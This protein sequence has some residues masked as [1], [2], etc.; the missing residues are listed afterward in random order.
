MTESKQILLIYDDEDIE[1]S[2]ERLWEDG[3]SKIG[4]VT[5]RAVIQ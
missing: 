3:K 2:I 1:Q 4:K 5:Q